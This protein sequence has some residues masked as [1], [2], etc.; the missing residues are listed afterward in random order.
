MATQNG[1]STVALEQEQVAPL[2]PTGRSAA[3]A[4]LAL[5]RMLRDN[6]WPVR[7]FQMVR[8]LERLHPERKPV[9]IFVAPADEVAR[10]SAHT[11]LAFPASEIQSFTEG[12]GGPDRLQVNFMGLSTMNGPLPA[13]YTEM[14]LER[15]RK[16]DETAG[17]FFDIF[18]HR[19]VSLFY[20]AWKKYR[21]YIAYEQ[22]R[23]QDD[24]VTRL[25]YD[26]LGL[27]SGG[28]RNRMSVADEAAIFY[29]GL[30]GQ[31]LRTAQG[32]QQILA[33]YFHV[34]I[35]VEQFT[36]N[37]NRLPAYDHT[38]LR[39]GTTDSE[40][41]GYAAVL[42]DE[43][44]DQQGTLTVRIGPMPLARYVQFLPGGTAH[45]QL[46]AWLRFYGRAEFDFVVKLVLER[47]EVPPVLLTAE[48]GEMA[49]LGFASWIRNRP[50]ARDPDEA[51][52]CLH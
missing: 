49:R 13:P 46:A 36:G 34:K 3:T 2:L 1:Q 7:F 47:N 10:F 38:C 30:L 8:L 21:F 4:N 45:P 33:D 48:T 39:Y 37:W 17:E 11:S 19:I 32:L 29:G 12:D 14:L 5:A 35:Q 23:G 50:F 27:G 22:S 42:G 25:L 28:L 31:N 9:G 15:A 16:K 26:L 24:L 51:T 18:N 6:P 40:R 52:Y 44:W 41:L 20:R 43:A